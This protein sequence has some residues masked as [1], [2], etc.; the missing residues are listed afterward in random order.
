MRLFF[1]YRSFFSFLIVISQF[2]FLYFVL[3]VSFLPFLR[4]ILLF[5]L[6]I[7][8]Y[9]SSF[10]LDFSLP[11]T[12]Q[13]IFLFFCNSSFHS[14]F[15]FYAPLFFTSIFPSPPN[16]IPSLIPPFHCVLSLLPFPPF[17]SPSVMERK[18]RTR[19][20]RKHENSGRSIRPNVSVSRVSIDV[21]EKY[22]RNN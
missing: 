1:S 22:R 9:S 8:F 10:S 6:H 5:P 3:L 17:T 4:F 18:E 11:F 2:F 14:M 19:T 15:F 12:L 21:K 13:T 16:Y 7:F 20:R